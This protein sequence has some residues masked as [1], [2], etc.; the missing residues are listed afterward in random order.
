MRELGR[1]LRRLREAE[2]IG[3]RQVEA[4]KGITHGVVGLVER[5]ELWPNFEVLHAYEAVT[6][7]PMGVFI[8][9]MIAAENGKPVS[10]LPTP[11]ERLGP[12]EVCKAIDISVRLTDRGSC[13]SWSVRWQSS[14]E[15]HDPTSADMFPRSKLK[16]IPERI[17]GPNWDISAYC[18]GQETGRSVGTSGEIASVA[19]S[20]PKPLVFGRASSFE[21]H[22]PRPYRGV[23]HVAIITSPQRVVEKLSFSIGPAEHVMRPIYRCAMPYDDF[24]QLPV[25]RRDEVNAS[26]VGPALS[27]IGPLENEWIYGVVWRL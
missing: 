25:R 22:C 3:Q 9:V 16:L 23:S 14:P 24:A 26:D 18:N 15:I 2:K 21:I 11:W 7:V 20:F 12:R 5:G 13:E 6:G 19:V 27:F 1:Y 4:A 8:R 10:E 17:L